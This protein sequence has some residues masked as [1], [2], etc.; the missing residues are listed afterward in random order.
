LARYVKP[1]WKAV[2]LEP[3]HHDINTN[4]LGN[5]AWT[6]ALE[7]PGQ[8]AFNKANIKDLKLE[9]GDKTGKFKTSGN[10]TFMQIFG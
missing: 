10:L 5:Q 9:N 2:D 8:K 3:W 7:W 6:E 4:I 1:A